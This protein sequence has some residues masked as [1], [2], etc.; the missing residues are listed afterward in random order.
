MKHDYTDE[1]IKEAENEAFRKKPIAK[2]HEWVKAF[3]DALPERQQAQAQQAT[4][5]PWTPAVGDTVRL[6]SGGPVMTVTQVHAD[7][8]FCQWFDQN[9]GLSNQPFPAACL[10]PAKP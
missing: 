1:E 3:L 6:K 5:Q 7:S 10:T 4:A 9:V 2:G 8:T